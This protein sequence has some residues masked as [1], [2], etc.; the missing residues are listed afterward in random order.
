MPTIF[1]RGSAN[2]MSGASATRRGA[3][4]SVPAPAPGD[5]L[6]FLRGD[7]SWAPPPFAEAAITTDALS[8]PFDP[9]AAFENAIG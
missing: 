2:P 3:G 4:G 5:Q 7:G 6:L 8:L 9:I 1:Q